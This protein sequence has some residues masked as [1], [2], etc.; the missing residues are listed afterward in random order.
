MTNGDAT[1]SRELFF[2]Y[3]LA[4]A[5][6]ASID[7]AEVTEYVLDGACALL[8]AEQGF[9]FFVDD[10][11]ALTPHSARGLN[12]D[13]LRFLAG[14]LPGI[15]TE[16]R[17][18][19]LEHPRT[20]EGA[21]LAVPLVAHNQETGV[22]GVA[23]VYTRRFTP[24][25]Q[26]R[27]ASV[28]NLASLAL[29]NASLHDRAQRELAMLRRLIQ[30]A[31]SMGMGEMTKE[32]AAELGQVMG[33][34]ELSRLGQAFGRMAQQVIQREEHLRREVEALTIQIDAAKQARQVAEITE[35]DYFQHLKTRA[36]ELRSAKKAPANR[37]K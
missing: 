20:A 33:R 21:I 7:L 5:F 13:E 35:T 2:L 9:I 24:Q 1:S 32:Q 17:T 22:I 11:G 26:E 36:K 3:E 19:T 23:T 12:D 25:E 10:D 8:G 29:E 31:Q 18:V 37:G 28:A 4:K 30:A 14:H 27:L 6:A 34:D 16:R 15:A